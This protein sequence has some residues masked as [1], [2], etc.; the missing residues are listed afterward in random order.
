MEKIVIIGAGHGGIQVASSLREE[1]FEGEIHVFSD[2]AEMP[3]QKPPLSK[4]YLQGK[5]TA[6]AI[7]FRS[8][9]F[10]ENNK[11][12]LQLGQQI[13]KILPKNKQI[14]TTSGEKFDFTYLVFATGASN[15]KLQFQGKIP[16]NILYLRN[17]SDAK[18]IEEKLLV[19]ENI[20][21]IGGGFIGLEIAAMAAEKGKAVTVIEAQSR[22]MER[23]LPA[24]ISDIFYQKHKENGVEFLLNTFTENVSENNE[25]KLR[26]GTVLKAD[27]V[28][29]GIGV[30]PN[31][32]L[33]EEAGINCKNGILVNEYQE[34]SLQN[35]Y[36][37]GDCAN[38]FNFYSQSNTRLE[39]VQ[40]AIDQAKVVARNVMGMKTVYKSV[41]W[42]WT[43]QYNLKLQM[44]GIS[45]NY[46]SYFIRGDQS[47]GK[48]SVYY[49]KNKKLIGV[50][51]VNKA[52]DHLNARK[53][54][55]A[56]VEISSEQV[57]DLDFN[58]NQLF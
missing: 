13:T 36:A 44:A 34:T 8:A 1:G 42:F 53:L 47:T 48:F 28:I 20:I 58:L 55:E 45:A 3:Y 35:I 18:R 7:L 12:Q 16:E 27:L 23:V 17:F 37:I 11:I 4:G 32:V 2:E 5:Q 40:N 6:E 41:P 33:A 14:E 54:L 29:A 49:F 56:E 10:Y 31:Y 25:V 19:S 57:E 38:H 22:L 52:A 26:D 39:S 21:V 50:D 51:S 43:F 9:A 46:D 15:R 24:L 30:I